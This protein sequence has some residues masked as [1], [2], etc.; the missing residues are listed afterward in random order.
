MKDI[1][2]GMLSW[3]QYSLLTAPS[4]L[5]NPRFHLTSPLVS[6]LFYLSPLVGF[7]L[8][9]FAGGKYSDV[10]VKKWIK[11]RGMRL[12][13]DRLNA[14]ITA[15]FGIV[16]LSF[17]VYGWGLQ[18]N[19]GGLAL[20]IVAAFFCA[21]GLLMAFA[22]LNTYCAEVLPKQRPEVIAGKYLIQ[23]AFSAAGSAGIV[24]LIDAIGIGPATTIGVALVLIAGCL[25]LVTAKYGLTMQ[26]WVEGKERK[27]LVKDKPPH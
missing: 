18:Y 1:A 3:S 21:M 11:R 15:L 20:P 6:G 12:P 13:Q 27:I 26:L 22:S 4:H 5:I 7:L 9:T 17:L 24:P 14:G 10:I 8:G 16:P 19:A 25:T 2:C 23:Y